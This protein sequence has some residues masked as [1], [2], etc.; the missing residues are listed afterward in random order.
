MEIENNNAQIA[1]DETIEIKSNNVQRQKD[2]KTKKRT[3]GSKSQNSAKQ[4]HITK[5]R[6]LQKTKLLCRKYITIENKT[7]A[8]ADIEH[9]LNLITTAEKILFKK[10]RSYQVADA[11]R[12]IIRG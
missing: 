11:L 6:L 1:E 12:E 10:I 3:E 4:I 8:L 9:S 5:H 7:R 2:Q